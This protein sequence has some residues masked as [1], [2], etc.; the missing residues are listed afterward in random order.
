MKLTLNQI[1]ALDVLRRYPNAI[2]M[3]NGYLTGGV[4]KRLD[5]RTIKAL[6]SKKLL[7]SDGRITTLGQTIELKP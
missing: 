1:L 4:E 2:V 7:G 3:S 6:L 5:G